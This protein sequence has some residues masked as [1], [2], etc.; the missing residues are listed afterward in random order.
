M[1]EPNSKRNNA[2]HRPKY[3][4]AEGMALVAR[5]RRS[6][7]S[8]RA[9]GEQH[10]VPANR[11]WYWAAKAKSAPTGSAKAKPDFH[12]VTVPTEVSPAQRQPPEVGVRSAA[13]AK[14][15]IVVVST[16]A[17]GESLHAVIE[18]LDA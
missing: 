14:A 7:L 16:Q 18:G 4:R 8:A 1:T 12:V 11:L 17:L 3:S 6:G 2:V 5:G 15:V 9:F 13:L 10:N